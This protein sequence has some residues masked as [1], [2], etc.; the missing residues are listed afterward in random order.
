MKIYSFLLVRIQKFVSS[1][2]FPKPGSFPLFSLF[3]CFYFLCLLQIQAQQIKDFSLKQTDGS[4][5]SSVT[6][7]SQKAWVVIFTGN[8]CVYSKKY[9]DRLIQ[10]AN[11]YKA[12]GVGF[13]LINSNDALQSEEES[14]QNMQ[15]RAKD[16]K[17]PFAY[18]QD[19]KQEVAIMFGAKK[20][21]EV[22]VL[23]DNL[24]LYQG[25]I[26]NNPLMPEKVSRHYLKEALDAVLSGKEVSEKGVSASGCNIKWK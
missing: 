1:H 23:K 10:F 8:H 6:F 9:E 18:L 4:T 3:F 24:I 21:P 14:L 26:D 22:F 20:N 7:K 2:R 16:K 13:M 17:F 15:Q 12:K 11:E 19:E 25:A 5:V